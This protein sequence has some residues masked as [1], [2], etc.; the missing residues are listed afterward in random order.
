VARGEVIDISPLLRRLEIRLRDSVVNAT[1]SFRAGGA[2][3]TPSG[4]EAALRRAAAINRYFRSNTRNSGCAFAV[5]AVVRKGLIDVLRKGE[6]D[7]LFGASGPPTAAHRFSHLR[8]MFHG[9]NAVL[10]NHDDYNSNRGPWGRENVIA[11]PNGGYWG[12]Y[13]DGDG[14]RVREYS[15]IFNLLH[16]NYQGQKGGRGTGSRESL[17]NESFDGSVEFLDVP[18]IAMKVFDYRGRR[19]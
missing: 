9:D 3:E 13:G 17:D 2:F 18:A 12:F 10:E 7:A 15:E 14:G 5:L 19:R 1:T 16:E 6:Y 11:M 8:Y 4:A